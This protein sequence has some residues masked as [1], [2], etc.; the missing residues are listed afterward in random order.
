MKLEKSNKTLQKK[1]VETHSIYIILVG[2]LY[3]MR[4]ILEESCEK[5]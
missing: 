2:N 4:N 3:K 1:G 5:S